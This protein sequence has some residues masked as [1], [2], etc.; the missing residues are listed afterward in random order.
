[1]SPTSTTT[2]DT[3]RAIE[4]YLT[5]NPGDESLGALGMTADG[6]IVRLAEHDECHRL[7]LH[8]MLEQRLGTLMPPELDQSIRERMIENALKTDVQTLGEYRKKIHRDRQIRN[9]LETL[10]ADYAAEFAIMHERTR[11]KV[12]RKGETQT[13]GCGTIA[14][15]AHWEYHFSNEFTRTHW[16]FMSN[17]KRGLNVDR[18][19]FMSNVITYQL[20]WTFLD[21][22][23]LLELPT[24]I[25]RC[26]ITNNRTLDVLRDHHQDYSTESFRKDFLETTDNGKSTVRVAQDLGLKIAGL[27]V[28]YCGN[29]VKAVNIDELLNARR[30][31][32][33]SVI[34]HVHPDSS[35]YDV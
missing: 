21:K 5:D 24:A 20:E 14:F 9:R 1:M 17:F 18:D 30:E 8:Q 4:R 34:V 2:E 13:E 23:W 19:F 29:P 26:K 12:G 7:E 16:K 11:T 10:K 15:K 3:T 6:R 31:R 35:F 22:R 25:E 32:T 28:T 33:F 27:T